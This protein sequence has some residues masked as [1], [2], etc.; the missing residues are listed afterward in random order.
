ME[1]SRFLRSFV[2][3]KWLVAI[4]QLFF[5]SF[6]E[7]WAD[8]IRKC[9]VEHTRLVFLLKLLNKILSYNKYYN[10]RG[11]VML[12]PRDRRWKGRRA[13]GSWRCYGCANETAAAGKERKW[14]VS[15][16]WHRPVMKL[17]QKLNSQ[18]LN[19][20]LY[21]ESA[22]CPAKLLN[23]LVLQSPCFCKMRTTTNILQHWNQG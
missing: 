5:F 12:G 10:S 15:G 3:Q 11:S 14:S 8:I 23:F 4:P 1:T 19:T 21:L 20:Q 7:V 16:P 18:R 2:D 17:A 22:G 9:D 13:L 6:I